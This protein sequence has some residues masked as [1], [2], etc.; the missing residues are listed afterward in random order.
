MEESNMRF[1]DEDFGLGA[2]KLT[3]TNSSGMEVVLTNFGARL[4]DVKIPVDDTLRSVVVGYDS[5]EGYKENDT[6]MGA[7]IGP[8]A[9][10]IANGDL[11]ID[12]KSYQLAQNEGET[13][14]HTGDGGMDDMIWNYSVVDG[15]D[16]FTVL[17]TATFEK[18]TNGYPSDVTLTATYTLTEE[19]ELILTIV[20]NAKEKTVLNPT[21]HAY[22]NLN[23][24]ADALEQKIQ[25]ASS[26]VLS[27]ADDNIP[28]GEF[29]N[30]EGTVFGLRTIQKIHR[31][32][33][34]DEET[35]LRDGFDHPF[36]LDEDA[37]IAA[38]L[39]SDDDK[40]KMVVTTNQPSIVFFTHNHGDVIG[41]N[42]E[43]KY[44]GVTFETQKLPDAIHHENFGDTVVQPEE[45]Y[46]SKTTFTFY[47]D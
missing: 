22:F 37:E 28:T 3:V 17:F 8:I 6:Y 15:L 40:V 1:R 7:T 27:L 14:L 32:F 20:G 26:R 43:D 42:A 19:N 25:M 16:R 39:V 12:G 10:R 30:V 46:A 9:G 5:A 11:L 38:T 41:P 13:S 23:A 29:R 36:V 47:N 18:G 35:K 44:C 21:N 2:R 24:N 33:D 4:V 34:D 45:Q 31:N